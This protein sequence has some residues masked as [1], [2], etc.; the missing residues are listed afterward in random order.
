[1]S[2][3]VPR[4]G[5]QRLSAVV[6]LFLVLVLL[7]PSATQAQN[8]DLLLV[9]SAR[10]DS[11]R[12]EPRRTGHIVVTSA[13]AQPTA[14]VGK[15]YNTVLAI[16]GGAA[17]YQFAVSSG[18]LPPGL[19]LNAKAG[20]ISG[21]PTTPGTYAFHIRVT[22]LPRRDSGDKW[23]TIISLG[24]APA[25][26]TVTVAPASS[27][28]GSGKS[29][30]FSALVNN[31]SNKAVTWRASIGSIS[32]SGLF[33]APQ[34]SSNA[35][36]TITAT[37][38]ANPTISGTAK[39]TISVSA[40]APIK[41]VVSPNPASLASGKTQ[42]FTAL[43][44]NTANTSVTWK[45]SS[46]TISGT[47]L[48]TAP[49]VSSSVSASVTATSVAA[50]TVSASATVTI[51]A[52]GPSAVTITTTAVPGGST[53]SAYGF[54]LA[55]TGG[56]SPYTWTISSGAL[57][58]GLS[59]AANGMISG[60]TSQTGQF[61]F[62]AQVTDSSSPAQHATQSFMLSISGVPTGSMDGPAQLPQVYLQTLLAN[63]PANGQVWNVSTS[64]AFQ[65][66]LNTAACGDTIMLQ[67]GAVFNGLF[68]FPQKACDNQHWIVVRTSAPD[69]ALPP[70][71][72]RMTPCYGGVSSLP[73]RPAFS[74]SST[75]K[76]LA[77]IAYS[78]TA[79]GP[80]QF[81]SGANH[82]RLIGLEITRTVGGLPVSSLVAPQV[83]SGADSIIVDRNWIH[84]TPLDD[85]RRGVQ[86]DGMTN[87]AVID[88]YLNDF[89]CTAVTGS[90]TDS[91]AISGGTGNLAMGPYK[92][93]NNF[94]ESAG[95]DIIF[96]G[97]AGTATPTDL[98]VRRNHFFKPMT[99]K[100]G[101]PGFI[102]ATFIVK[103]HFE[104]KNAKRVLVESNVFE[105]SW[106]GFSQSGFSI[107]ITPKNQSSN[108]VNIC[109]MCQVTDV[110]I[111]YNTVSHVAG[112]FQIANAPSA[113]GGL[114]LD[115]QRYSIHDI[116]ADDING[117]AYVG[118]GLFAQISS[119]PSPILQNVSINHIT[120]F[121]NS[122]LL[123]VG[124]QT[125]PKMP[126]FS[127]TNSLVLA[128]SYPIWSTGGGTANC[129][130][131][132]IPLTTMSSC[133]GPYSFASNAIL[134]SPAAFAVAKWPLGNQFGTTAT[135]Q[136]V[137]YNN[138]N[139]GDY[140]LLSSSPYKNAASDG[141]D[142]GANINAVLSAIAGVP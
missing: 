16:R 63:T 106:G 134:N 11:L 76:V 105:N 108:G 89:H 121:P 26:V 86:T 5:A 115:G 32:S 125:S 99:W 25:P 59:L 104:L 23:L 91:Q 20:S 30:Q 22:D 61:S 141:L 126:N 65:Q 2:A 129:A 127:F 132:D 1:M 24:S 60:T 37:S 36:A 4:A 19:S 72:V 53:G 62:V 122:M 68:I 46:G 6:G 43:V 35:S 57:P 14:S 12:L 58:A 21:T 54:G 133:F 29:Q 118:T 109:P 79:N 111:R 113:T 96:G 123:N 45:A 94:L 98:E 130:Y 73:G 28:V 110:T 101:A 33:T 100:Q 87:V 138:G 77:T 124:G 55:A 116:I 66:A 139:G 117:A 69:T 3:T 137:N 18:T 56:T 102:G 107:V 70:E 74:C 31:T 10:L 15:A 75:Q 83:N 8:A 71:G 40:P 7:I 131:Y 93:V 41:V 48:Y 120:A 67:A 135:A 97:G 95:E 44:S 114:P 13:P 52:P 136:F 112:V 39:V 38:V 90:C 47:G 17:P 78:G 119:V 34:V 49:A 142:I 64:A 85:T 27:T 92:I 80:V 128:G 140:H 42:Q 82:Y 88:S 50:P 84:G 103:N 9:R 81:A 51:S